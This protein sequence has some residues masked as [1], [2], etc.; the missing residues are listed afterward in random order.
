M[1]TEVEGATDLVRAW[2]RWG[3]KLGLNAATE[4]ARRERRAALLKMA[5]MLKDVVEMKSR[6]RS[7][8]SFSTKVKLAR[9]H[10]SLANVIRNQSYPRFIHSSFSVFTFLLSH[11]CHVC[12]C[13]FVGN[14]SLTYYSRPNLTVLIVQ[15]P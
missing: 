10:A 13:H 5:I 11:S 2:L 3:V 9:L 1:G 14:T 8:L 4:V 6:F 12:H 7:G 15:I